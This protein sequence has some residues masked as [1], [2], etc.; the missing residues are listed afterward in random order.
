MILFRR[1]SLGIAVAIGAAAFLNANVEAAP[2]HNSGII[3]SIRGS[4]EVSAD[5]GKTWKKAQVGY[6]LGAN[7][8]IKTGEGT[9][10]DIFLGENGPVVRVRDNTTMGIDK[11]DL[12]NTGVEKVIETQLDLKNGQILGS[13]KKMA[14]ASK[15]EVKTPVGVAGIRGTEYSINSAGQLHVVSGTVVIVYVVNGIVM[16][17]AQVNA[18][19]TA[20]PP[21]PGGTTA[22]LTAMTAATLQNVGADVTVI[23]ASVTVTPTG[24][25]QTTLDNGQTAGTNGQTGGT[26]GGTGGTFGN[27][28][29]TTTGTSGG[30]QNNGGNPDQPPQPPPQPPTQ[31]PPTQPDPKPPVNPDLTNCNLTPGDPNRPENCPP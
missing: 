4:A 6:R 16:P 23:T 31:Q 22:V 7:S 9:T 10:V 20:N 13:V 11:L 17:P 3:R 21:A 18:G 28:N 8:A 30:Q 5:K 2:L 19:T 12:D 26:T 29:T 14:A 24:G 25:L 27:S 1:L 15:Y